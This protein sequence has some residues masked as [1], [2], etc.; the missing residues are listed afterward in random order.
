MLHDFLSPC[1]NSFNI[2]LC[3]ILPRSC[4][5]IPI[6][7]IT[8]IEPIIAFGITLQPSLFSKGCPLLLISFICSA[9]FHFVIYSWAIVIRSWAPM[10]IGGCRSRGLSEPIWHL[11]SPGSFS[12]WHWWR[13][14]GSV[15]VLD[16]GQGLVLDRGLEECWCRLHW[17]LLQFLLDCWML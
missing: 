2:F 11:I 16:R 3:Q 14:L 15:R 12:T 17:F 7:I 13:G 9:W 6:H 5:F 4:L 1:L 10:S 8:I